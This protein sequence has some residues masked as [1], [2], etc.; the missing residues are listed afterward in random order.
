AHFDP[1][2]EELGLAMPKT[3]KT[4]II[5]RKPVILSDED[6]HLTPAAARK[7][8]VR[9]MFKWL[10]F[11]ALPLVI[12]QAFAFGSMVYCEALKAVGFSARSAIESGDQAIALDIVRQYESMM[13]RAAWYQRHF[14]QF[15]FR[16]NEPFTVFFEKA[17]PAQLASFYAFG[18]MH[19]LW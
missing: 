12:A 4:I 13:K 14:G 5:E 2:P 16:I 6:I 7:A 8:A 11:I 19:H 3:G 10:H 1:T 18:R 17:A 9:K 15:A